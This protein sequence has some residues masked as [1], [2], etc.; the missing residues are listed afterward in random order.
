MRYYGFDRS[1]NLRLRFTE[2]RKCFNK[3]I[4]ICGAKYLLRTRHISIIVWKLRN[5]LWFGNCA[6]FKE[7]PTFVKKYILR[8][9]NDFCETIKIYGAACF[10]P[11]IESRNYSLSYL[12]S[13]DFFQ[14]KAQVSNFWGRHSKTWK[15]LY[16]WR[17]L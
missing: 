17:F 16:Y 13:C 11:T 5:L 1:S 10:L 3:T 9:L 14:K 6:F 4:N 2:R 8:H 7:K 12:K 15:M